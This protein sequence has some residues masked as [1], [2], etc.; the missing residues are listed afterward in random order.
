MHRIRLRAPWKATWNAGS[1]TLV[2]TRNFHMPTG[3][4]GQAIALEITLLPK[5][6]GGENTILS[7]LV[8]GRLLLAEVRSVERETDRVLHFQLN[9]LEKFNF[10]ELRISLINGITGANR[11]E[12]ETAST[13]TFGSFVIESVELQID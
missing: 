5:D 4:E 6:Q 13:P 10:L 3:A 11:P 2:Y 7:V 12:F 9:E 8:N 1:L